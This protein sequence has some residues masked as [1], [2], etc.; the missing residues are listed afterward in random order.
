MNF[1]NKLKSYSIICYSIFM[2]I[3]SEKI[4]MFF[5]IMVLGFSPLQASYAAMSNCSEMMT[6]TMSGMMMEMDHS[7][8]TANKSNNESNS[9]SEQDC[10]N[11]NNCVFVHCA[12]TVTAALLSTNTIQITT[13]VSKLFQTNNHSLNSYFKSSI[14]RPPR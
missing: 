2:R 13:L 3:M 14:Y 6:S 10:C 7:D 8:L 11:Q 12:N 5:L 1:H 9:N 4:Y